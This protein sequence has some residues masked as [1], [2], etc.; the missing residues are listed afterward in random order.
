MIPVG[1]LVEVIQRRARLE[2]TVDADGRLDAARGR[3]RQNLAPS[4]PRTRRRLGSLHQGKAGGKLQ[5]GAD[6]AGGERAQC[7]LQIGT[8]LRERDRTDEPALRR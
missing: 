4:D 2:K 5:N 1:G 6:T 7:R 3:D 8:E